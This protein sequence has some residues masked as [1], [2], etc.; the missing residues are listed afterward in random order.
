VIVAR[1]APE[2][3]AP[4]T[5]TSEQQAE[6]V[7]EEAHAQQS[8]HIEVMSVFYRNQRG[9]DADQTMTETVRA[10][11]AG[12]IFTA[13]QLAQALHAAHPHDEECEDYA[14]LLDSARRLLRATLSNRMSPASLF[15]CD[16]QGDQYIRR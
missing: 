2:P 10:M 15:L 4:Q 8:A 6:S 11:P 5:E 9:V 7:V 1:P 12:T 3:P 13:E 14:F 16:E